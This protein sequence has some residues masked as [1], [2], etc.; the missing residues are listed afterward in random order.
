[1]GDS[2]PRDSSASDRNL[3]LNA[4]E[5]IVKQ[6]VERERLRFRRFNG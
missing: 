1:M 4:T 5:Q 6:I 3:R 2:R